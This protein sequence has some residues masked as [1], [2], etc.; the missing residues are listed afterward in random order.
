MIDRV[1]KN[2]TNYFSPQRTFGL[3]GCRKR[4]I[5]MEMRI[6]SPTGHLLKVRGAV[7]IVETY[8]DFNTMASYGEDVPFV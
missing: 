5:F 1:L 7:P 4:G 6:V 3:G 2:Q 8:V